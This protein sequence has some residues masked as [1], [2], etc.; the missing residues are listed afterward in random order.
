[1]KPVELSVTTKLIRGEFVMK[2]F[3]WSVICAAM[4]QLGC[5]AVLAQAPPTSLNEAGVEGPITGINPTARTITVGGMVCE[6]P[7]DLA[8]GGTNGITGATLSRLLDTAAPNRVRSIFQAGLGEA[9]YTAGTLIA[10]G[11][12]VVQGTTTRHV[13]SVAAVELA[14]NSVIGT[15]SSYNATA[16]SFVVNGITCR[17]NPDERFPA[18]VMSLAGQP[19]AASNLSRGVNTPV[20]V[21]GYMHLGVLYATLVETELLPVVA[22]AD[23]VSVIRA[24][25][26][27][28]GNILGELRVDG[29]VQPFAVNAVVTVSDAASGAVLGTAAVTQSLTVPGQGEFSFRLRNVGRRVTSVRVQSS[30]RGE[31][32]APVTIR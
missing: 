4:L 21:T 28:R 23:T 1:M 30:G 16:G 17:M 5:G 14:E 25:A 19:M 26:R 2:F 11:I 31:V 7:P 24:D 18:V 22:G 29:V 32:T 6:I 3:A 15:M 13:M 27:L 20:L 12:T 8:I 10:E 9:P